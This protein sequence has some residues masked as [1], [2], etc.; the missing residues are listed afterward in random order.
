M[1]KIMLSPEFLRR[2]K[3]WKE[4]NILFCLYWTMQTR[5]KGEERKNLT[6]TFVEFFSK[7]LRKQRE[8]IYFKTSTHELRVPKNVDNFKVSTLN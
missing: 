6:T 8:T 5:E 4:R 7:A 2:L 3:S 1:I